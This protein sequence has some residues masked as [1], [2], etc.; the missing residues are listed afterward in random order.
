M[1]T[2][3]LKLLT[4]IADEALEK[5]LTT[6]LRQLGAKGYTIAQARGSG[7]EGDRVSEWEGENIRLETIVSDD[8]ADKILE[9]LRK[10]YFEKFDII[11]YMTDVQVLRAE[12]FK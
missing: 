4:I 6:D 10:T 11:A 3:S 12:R 5:K 2:A 9:K 7:D 8:V 1:Q